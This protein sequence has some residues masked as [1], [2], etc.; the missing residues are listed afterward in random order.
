MS[1]NTGRRTRANDTNQLLVEAKKQRKNLNNDDAKRRRD[2]KEI[3]PT[4]NQLNTKRVQ[5]TKQSRQMII[6]RV[7][8]FII[9]FFFERFCFMLV[10]FELSSSQ[11]SF[12]SLTSLDQHDDDAGDRED[13]HQ[14]TSITC[15]EVSVRHPSRH[16][17]FNAV[18]SRASTIP[19][20]KSSPYTVN[21]V[22]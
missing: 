12:H 16:Y 17:N 4:N 2:K 10:L 3:Y 18:T 14:F 1:E 20:L 13:R 22:L 11:S 8:A 5:K 6:T 21:D 15:S 9:C 19:P 7:K